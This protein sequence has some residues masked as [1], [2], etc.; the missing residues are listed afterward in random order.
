MRIFFNIRKRDFLIEDT[1]GIEFPS[2]NAAYLEANLSVRE[3]VASMVLKGEPIDG[4]ALEICGDDGVL[5]RV[6]PFR[7][8][9][10]LR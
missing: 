3:L 4:E 7:D 9:I 5:I 1:E 8:A 2:H 10:I 6:L